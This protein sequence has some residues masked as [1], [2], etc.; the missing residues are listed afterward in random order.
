MDDKL[1]KELTANLLDVF[2]DLR[3]MDKQNE[4]LQAEVNRLE[5]AICIHC[6]EKEELE[7]VDDD[8]DREAIEWFVSENEGE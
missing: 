4:T 6:R 1:F 2:N 5:K 7:Q 3:V 8:P